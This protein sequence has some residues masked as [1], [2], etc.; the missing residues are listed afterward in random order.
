MSPAKFSVLGGVPKAQ[1]AQFLRLGES[2]PNASSALGND[3]ILADGGAVT[4]D[5]LRLRKVI[6]RNTYIV[7]SGGPLEM[8]DVY[9]LNCTFNV[10]QQPNGRALVTAALKP[11]PATTFGAS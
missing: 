7:Y 8:Q 4:I 9:F 10:K 3:W 1:A 11:S 6:F 5:N 2:D